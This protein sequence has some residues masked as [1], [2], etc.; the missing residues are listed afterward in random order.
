MVDLKDDPAVVEA[1]KAHHRRVWPDVLRSLKDAGIA[2]MEIYLLGRRLVMIVDTNGRD[3]HS[4]F[5]AHVAS[6]PRIVEWEALMKSMQEP[7]PDS[8]P[9]EWWAMMQPVFRLDPT[10]TVSARS[11]PARRA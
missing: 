6:H 7:A 2:E 10:E 5:A 9:G 1:Y 11:E 4:C 3:V 8:E